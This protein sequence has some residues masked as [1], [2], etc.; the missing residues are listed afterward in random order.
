MC[1]ST[2]TEEN[3]DTTANK[4]KNKTR[5][6]PGLQPF[7]N[8]TFRLYVDVREAR[9]ERT[10]AERRGEGAE[11]GGEEQRKEGTCHLLQDASFT[12]FYQQI[13]CQFFIVLGD[14]Q[15]F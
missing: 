4:Q 2:N 14:R 12:L 1:T 7:W 15:S 6:A 9:G 3:K 13:S 11:K 8:D 10:Q 5:T